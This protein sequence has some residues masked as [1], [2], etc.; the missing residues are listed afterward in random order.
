MPV[1]F[2]IGAD[3]G[4]TFTDVVLLGSDGSVRTAKVSSTPDNYGRAIIDGITRLVKEGGLAFSEIDRVVH[5]TTVATN[6]ILKGTGAKTALITTAGFRDVLE[7]ARTRYARLFDINTVKLKPLVRRQRRFEVEERVGPRGDVWRPLDDA[8]ATRVIERVRSEDVQSLAICLIHSYVN[9]DHEQR[10]AEIA[11]N[12]LPPG[13]FITCSSDVLP[14]IREYERTSTTVINAYLGPVVADY[15][16]S[17]SREPDRLRY[18]GAPADH[19]VQWRHHVFERR[20]EAA[21]DHR[22]VGSRRRCDRRCAGGG[23]IRLSQRHHPGPR[24]DHGQG[25]DRRGWPGGEVFGNGSGGRRELRQ[26][27][28]HGPRARPETSRRRRIGGWG[29]GRQSGVRRCLQASSCRTEKRRRRAGSGVLRPGWRAGHP[30]RCSGHPGLPQSRVLGWWRDAAQ[31]RQGG[32]GDVGAG[33]ATPGQ[34]PAG[35]GPRDHSGRGRKH[36]GRGPF[37]IDPSGTGPPGF[38]PLRLRW[39]R[40]R[41][42][43]PIWRG[44]WA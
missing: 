17:L 9:P 4:G 18:H 37:R 34:E 15:V 14:E 3:I 35:G 12:V 19:A 20:D 11:R 25:F 30:D 29:G 38:R 40:V 24:G 36:D 28:V 7:L 31:L 10:I 6:T 16:V 39:E 44:S 8:D 2:R 33:G 1:S 22:R 5:G 23:D 42:W 27:D 21:R 13:V 43:L 41:C 26:Q 32:A